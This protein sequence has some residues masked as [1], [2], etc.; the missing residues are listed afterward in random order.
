MVNA[1]ALIAL[2][3]PVTLP[4][5]VRHAP[6]GLRCAMIPACRSFRVLENV[7]NAIQRDWK[8]CGGG[9]IDSPLAAKIA[10]SGLLRYVADATEMSPEFVFDST[11][12]SGYI[13]EHAQTISSEIEAVE[14]QPFLMSVD[15]RTFKRLDETSRA[16]PG[17]TRDRLDRFQLEA[18]HPG[19]R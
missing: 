19:V 2:I 5:A 11:I 18:L 4:D 12:A 15:R 13:L 3:D 9:L 14:F 1:V 10:K 6:A 17:T 7:A 16:W 8:L